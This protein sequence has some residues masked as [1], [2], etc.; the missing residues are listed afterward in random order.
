[1]TSD[2][3]PTPE[4]KDDDVVCPDANPG[5][6][7]MHVSFTNLQPTEAELAEA[8]QEIDQSPTG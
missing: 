3:A 5:P 6:G 2:N 8:A 7:E 4:S 1:M